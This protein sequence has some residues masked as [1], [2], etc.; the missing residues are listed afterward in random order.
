ML[1]NICNTTSI[2]HLY[3]TQ[4]TERPKCKIVRTVDCNC[5]YVSITAVLIIFPVSLQTVIN[6]IMLSIGKQGPEV[7]LLFIPNSRWTYSGTACQARRDTAVERV[8]R[9]NPD[10]FLGCQVIASH[11]NQSYNCSTP[12][13]YAAYTAQHKQRLTVV[14]WFFLRLWRFI[15]HLLTYFTYLLT[16]PKTHCWASAATVIPA[17]RHRWTC[18]ALTPA[19]QVSSI[20]HTYHKEMARLSWPWCW[21]YIEMAYLPADSHPSKY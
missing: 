17:T 10:E 8:M 7:T 5:A 20:R 16:L 9:W 1:K 21:L 13:L 19:R 18:P 15:N 2:L 14:P 6:L 4:S 11:C 3:E 12:G